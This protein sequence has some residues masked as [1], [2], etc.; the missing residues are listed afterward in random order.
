MMHY[1]LETLNFLLN[2]HLTFA[3]KK[4]QQQQSLNGAKLG[5]TFASEQYIFFH[6]L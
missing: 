5:L 3:F 2:C 4:Q 6:P 1:E